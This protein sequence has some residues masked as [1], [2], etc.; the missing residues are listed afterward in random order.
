MFDKRQKGYTIVELLVV[1]ALM[2][3][4]VAIGTPAVISQISHLRLKKTTRNVVIELNAAR[5]HAISQNTIYRVE[6]T[7]AVYPAADTFRL[8]KWSGGAW[9][10]DTTRAVKVF[11]SGMDMISPTSDFNVRFFPNG[12]ADVTTICIQNTHKTSDKMQ[13]DVS[14]MTGRIEVSGC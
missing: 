12:T 5:M 8:A 9:A 11:D 4:M 13:V 7:L 2:A 6:F 14:A 10:D 3:T 1:I